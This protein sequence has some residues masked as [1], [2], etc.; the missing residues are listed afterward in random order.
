[1]KPK[2]NNKPQKSEEKLEKK[3]AK[4]EPKQTNDESKLQKTVEEIE[5]KGNICELKQV[6]GGSE[7]ENRKVEIKAIKKI[8]V[9]ERR[10]LNSTRY[11]QYNHFPVIT[12]DSVRCKN[13]GCNKKDVVKCKKCNVHLCLMKR[14]NCFTNFHLLNANNAGTS[15]VICQSTEVRPKNSIRFDEH[16]HFP[17]LTPKMT[18]CKNCNRTTNI[19][20]RKCK[21]HLCLVNG[22][23]CFMDFHVL[24]LEQIKIE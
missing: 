12:K 8:G 17:I 4:I 2:V 5:V 10:P 23:N 19:C 20:C 18:P 1:M 7:A 13:E 16:N 6:H 3:D 9:R 21:V 22:R 15:E 14:R 11:D 24:S